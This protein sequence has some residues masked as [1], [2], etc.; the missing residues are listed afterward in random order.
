VHN[1]CA[2]GAQHMRTGRSSAIIWAVGSHG[3]LA[4]LVAIDIPSG[5][6]LCVPPSE[7]WA[8]R[9]AIELDPIMLG[10]GLGPSCWD[11]GA[12]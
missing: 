10:Y 3:V 8:M 4:W 12:L 11:G 6:V 5:Y 9:C 7:C 2:M 1:T